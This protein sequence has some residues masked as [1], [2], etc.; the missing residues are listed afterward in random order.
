MCKKKK[1]PKGL[2][3]SRNPANTKYVYL[4]HY[5][6]DYLKYVSNRIKDIYFCLLKIYLEVKVWNRVGCCFKIVTFS[7]PSFFPFLRNLQPTF[8]HQHLLQ[9]SS[10]NLSLSPINTSSFDYTQPATMSKR[11]K[12]EDKEVIDLVKDKEDEAA[13]NTPVSGFSYVSQGEISKFATRFG[14]S[15]G[16]TPVLRLS[17]SAAQPSSEINPLAAGASTAATGRPASGLNVWYVKPI[18]G[19][20]VYSC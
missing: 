11:I 9:T 7:C 13:D 2:A 6:V 4:V 8:L 10:Q 16:R 17:E 3:A 12:L 20:I 1:L 5:P 19:C 18:H 14:E 15:W